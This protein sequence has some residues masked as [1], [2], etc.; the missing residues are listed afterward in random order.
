MS[1]VVDDVRPGKVVML[2]QVLGCETMAKYDLTPLRTGYY[3]ADDE[4]CDA[5]V[6]NE[7]AA[8]AFRFGHTLIRSEFP[9]MDDFFHNFSRPVMLRESFMN[10]SSLY[11]SSQVEHISVRLRL[12]TSPCLSQGG[13]DTLMIGLVGAAAETFDRHIT[14]GVRD[15]LF[16][17]PRKHSAPPS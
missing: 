11:D 4:R 8:A 9:R 2:V 5:T 14:S 6:S 12:R 1:F 3:R 7:F 16:E 13:V 15:H 17:R 10:T